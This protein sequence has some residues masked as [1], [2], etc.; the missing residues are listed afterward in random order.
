MDILL[1]NFLYIKGFK[2]IKLLPYIIVSLFVF[3][4]DITPSGPDANLYFGLAK[5]LLSDVGYIDTIRNDEILP[6]IGYPLIIAFAIKLGIS[7]K[8]FAYIVLISSLVLLL[9]HLLS[10]RINTKLSILL[11]LVFVLILPPLNIWGIELML[12]FLSTLLFYAFNLFYV[13][14]SIYFLLFFMFVLLLNVLVRPLLMPFIYLLIPLVIYYII[15]N[16]TLRKGIIITSIL[17]FSTLSLIGNYSIKQYE[18]K[19]FLTGTY[20]EIPLYCAWNNHISLTTNYYSSN[21]N[22]LTKDKKSLATA[23][24][25]NKS[26]WQDRAKVLK[27]EVITF[28]IDNP[29]K[30]IKGYF[31]RLSKF[32]YFPDDKLYG[33]LIY[34]SSILFLIIL[35]NYKNLENRLKML[36]IFSSLSSIY[37]ISITSVFIFVNSRYY[38]TPSLFLVFTL[39]YYLYIFSN[40]KNKLTK[41]SKSIL[42]IS[43]NDFKE[44]SIQV[45]R[46]TPEA[47]VANKWD[48]DYL[49]SRDNAKSANYFYEKEINPEG[50][51]V[52][53]FY[54]PFTGIKDK[55]NNHLGQTI[56]SKLLGFL[57][58]FILFFKAT[59][60]LKKKE[61]SIIY[62]YEIHGVLAS[63]LIKLFYF[64]RNYK[65][66][67]RFQGTW[68]T[69]YLKEKNIVKLLL[70]LEVIWAMKTKSDLCIM[71]DDGTQ[72]DQSL[73]LLGSKSLN[74]YR[75]WVNGVDE[76]KISMKDKEKFAKE[77]KI[78][79]E[80][81]FLSV[82]RL[83]EWKRVDR[84]ILALSKIKHKNFRYF[85][86]G[87]GYQKEKLKQLVRSLNMSDKVVF[88]GAI[89]NN[90]VKKY[91]N[92]ADYF[93]STY[94]LS[95]VG[96]PLLEA[97][98][99][100]KII[101]TINNGDTSKWIKHEVNGFIY[102][103]N[104]KLST[105]M[106]YD[107]DRLLANS[108]LE[109]EINI[110]V[111]KLEADKLWTWD[112]R[113]NR[114]V[115]EVESLINVK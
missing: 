94:N 26:G 9:K 28:V 79:N 27:N 14:K 29:V 103:I 43:A 22:S 3:L 58:I 98:R 5:N 111:K 20:S 13:N 51:N 104:E 7:G 30:A 18:D 114:E 90:E 69:K 37:V 50:V 44:K 42:F 52:N 34:S 91:L 72:G 88:V 73:K 47:Y 68:L 49:V 105:S 55:I 110:G 63:Q 86:V 48:V 65:Y 95:N 19:R 15:Y 67:N 85:I 46:K 61:T 57:I 115:E 76:Q 81:I 40:N 8:V 92:I 100:N 36:F 54:V 56:I 66:I 41:N 33:F 97:I 75:F 10:L 71:T 109:K 101:F 113:M 82:C 4:I 1:V 2:I 21:W 32:S 106:A 99:A 53:R 77:L 108:H 45:I 62:G 112:E 102:N 12:I 87:D 31:W 78:S 96:N 70:N 74:N 17:F 83:E 16:K 60:L 6:S 35:F 39:S 84:S 11:I 38:V 24:L 23:P 59:K 89:P 80:K 93:F 107:I 25:K 64:S